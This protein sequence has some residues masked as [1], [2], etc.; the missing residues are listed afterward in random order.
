MDSLR[1]LGFHF[2]NEVLAFENLTT[3]TNRIKKHSFDRTF[4]TYERK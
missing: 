2:L 1:N 4:F 3:V